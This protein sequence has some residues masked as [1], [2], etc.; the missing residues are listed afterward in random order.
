M[1]KIGLLASLILLGNVLF[2]QGINEGKQFL[3]YERYQSAEDVFKKLVASDPN[4]I[5]AVYWL[6]QTY[7]AN[8]DIVDTTSAKELYQKTLQANPNAPLIM[9]GIGQVEL[10]EGKTTD[11]RNHFETA[12]SLAKKKEKEDIQEAVGRANVL[13]KNGDIL[14]G[15]AKLNEAAEKDKKNPEIYNLIGEGYWK[16]NDGSNAIINY[17]KALAIDAK[18]ARASWM[19]GRI[20]ETQGYNQETIYMK[21]Y[22]DAINEDANFAPVYYWLYGYYYNRD[23]NTAADYLNKYIA[24]AD[25]NSKNCYAKASLMY[26]SKK[27]PETVSQADACITEAGA[28]AYPNLYGL[29]AYAYDKMGDSSKSKEAFE[30]FF[31]KVNPDNIGPKDYA[32]YGKVLLQFPGQEELAETNINKALALDTVVKNKVDFL[33]DIAKGFADKKNYAEAG[34]WYGRVLAVDSAFGKTDLFYAGYNDYRGDNY[35][36]SDSVFQLYQ[37]KYP[38]DPLGWY[39]GGHAK[40]GIDTSGAL[41]L[42][43]PDYQK[44]IDIADTMQDKSTVKDKLIPS[45]RYMVAYYYNIKGQAD[46]ALMYNNKILEVDPTDATALKTKDALESV[47]KNRTKAAAANKPSDSTKPK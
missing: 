11:A 12:I 24:V 14:Y 2:A 39:M 42:A 19:I 43:R 10:R 33:K 6:G 1:K 4:N 21:H 25:N 18:D 47:I 36:T 35:K 26:V 17:Q 41:G 22:L 46:T 3:N 40:E 30:Q 20:Y 23:V 5:E 44:V 31:A 13:A 37:Q 7:L 29:K 28:K 27:Y 16:L 32:T 15:I 38:D 9:V 34:K 8:Q 45:Y